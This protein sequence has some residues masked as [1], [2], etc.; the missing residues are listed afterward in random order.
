MITGRCSCG[1]VRYQVEGDPVYAVL[2]HCRD[3]QRASGTGHVPVMGMPKATFAV[4]GETKSYAVRGT[5]GLSAIRYFCP[6]CGS[7]LFGMTEVAPE[8]VSIYVGTLD[9]PSTFQPEAVMFTRNRHDWDV[10]TKA[11]MEFETMPPRSN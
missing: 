7:L 3:C 1:A 10:T 6:T 11:L 2:C 9:D 8:A 4:Q 5:S